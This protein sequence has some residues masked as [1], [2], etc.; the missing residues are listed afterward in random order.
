MSPR[1]CSATTPKIVYYIREVP[2]PHQTTAVRSE[3]GC[4]TALM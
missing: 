2:Q 4:H 1:P 3:A